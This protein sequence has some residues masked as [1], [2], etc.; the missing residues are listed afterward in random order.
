MKKLLVL[1][2]EGN[3]ETGF[4]VKWEIGPDGQRPSAKD[5]SRLAFPACPK[6]VQVYKEWE[7]TYRSL[8]GNRIKPNPNQITNVKYTDLLSTCQRNA[9]NLELVINQWFNS[10]PL[11]RIIDEDLLKNREDEYRIII[12]SDN[13]L[14]R[15]IPWLLWKGWEKFPH[16]EISLGSPYTQRRDRIYQQ[17]VRILV[18]LGNE[19]G[20]DINEDRQILENYRQQGAYV[21]FLVQP[22]IEELRRQLSDECGWDT[23]S[24]SGHSR[25]ELGNK[26]RIYINQTDSLTM[27]QLQVELAIAI[28]KGLQLAIFNSCDGLGI[29]AELEALYI[30]QVIVMRQPVP[31]RVAQKFLKYFLAEFTSGK[32]LY[33]S[34][35]IARHQLEELQSDFPC[36]SWLPVIIQNH[37]EIPPTWQ[38]LGSIP[39]CPYR[40][41]AAFRVEDK[42][43]FYGREA[44][45]QSLLNAI[46]SQSIVTLVGASGSGKSS[47]VFAGLVPNLGGNWQ[48]ISLRPESNL[49]EA[50]A[51]AISSLIPTDVNME[52][53]QLLTSALVRAIQ[54]SNLALGNFISQYQIFNS[55]RYLLL[56]I[57]QLEEL[58][59]LEIDRVQQEFFLSNIFN[60]VERFP[61]FKLLSVLRADCDRYIRSDPIWANILGLFSTQSLIPMTRSE[62]TDALII[63]AQHLNV[64]FEL[65]LVE[66][67]LD[68]FP[69]KDYSLPLLESIVTQLWEK[70]SDGYLTHSA[71]ENIGRAEGIITVRA[72]L[73]YNQSTPQDREILRT[74][75]TQLIKVGSNNLSIRRTAKRPELGNDSWKLVNDLA[76]ARLVAIDRDEITQSETVELIHDALFH[77]WHTFLK[78]IELDGDFRQW[79]EQLRSDIARWEKSNRNDDKLLPASSLDTAI[80]W[81]DKYPQTNLSE[82]EFIDLSSIKIKENNKNK[83]R[84]LIVVISTIGA[85]I[86]GSATIYQLYNTNV[87]ENT[88]RLTATAISFATQEITALE[89]A[90]K[91]VENI[92][93][94]NQKSDVKL[95]AIIT[96]LNSLTHIHERKISKLSHSGIVNSV[97]FSQDNLMIVSIN[98]NTKLNIYDVDKK[99]TQSLPFGGGSSSQLV[100][101]NDK[102]TII[103]FSGKRL[104]SWHLNLSTGK[105]SEDS[106]ITTNENIATVGFSL[107]S[108]TLAIALDRK[109]GVQLYK[110]SNNNL[111]KDRLLDIS[112]YI[113]CLKFTPDGNK[114]VT[115]NADGTVKLWAVTRQPQPLILQ[116]SEKTLTVAISPDGESIATGSDRGNIQLWNIQGKPLYSVKHNDRKVKDLN[117][118]PDSKIL[119]STKEQEIEIWKINDRKLKFLKLLPV[120]TNNTQSV[121]FNP[122]KL[123]IQTLVSGNTDGTTILWQINFPPSDFNIPDSHTFNYS[124]DGKSLAV[125]T[126]KRN[127]IVISPKQHKRIVDYPTNHKSKITGVSISSDRQYFATVAGDNDEIKLWK[128]DGENSRPLEILNLAGSPCSFSPKESIMAIATKNNIVSIYDVKGK[129]NLSWGTNQST[130]TYLSFTPDG[131]NIITGDIDGKV[132]L[133]SLNGGLF[134]EFQSSPGPVVDV[135]SNPDGIIAIAS[136]LDREGIVTLWSRDGKPIHTLNKLNG[137]TS[138]AFSQDGN[139]ILTGN[140]EGELQLW[141]LS[142]ESLMSK[143]LN[144]GDENTEISKVR[145]STNDREIVAVD[146]NGKTIYYNLDSEQL[147]QQA[148]TL[149]LKSK[150]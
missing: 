41:L 100:I 11:S 91:A 86:A 90:Q 82:R 22:G 98:D 127:I 23:I 143:P 78:W 81:S 63:P 122:I 114:I 88:R 8:D 7:N 4:D 69:S 131:N 119:A 72:E 107:N 29:A 45:I 103:S 43:Y 68:S 108:Q 112:D 137:I 50:L 132:K 118:S 116:P 133:W 148:N 110:K 129:V 40:G 12:C 2:L 66:K 6:I 16:L 74:I 150:E 24:F 61:K 30:P 104:A 42:D 39:P 56:I 52:E 126:Q 44:S 84:R 109:A 31:D 142:G 32:S 17:Q 139:V 33:E 54:T 136:G 147:Q 105:W 9:D 1:N 28:E 111:T 57:D 5:I 26:G 128:L 135:S 35:S 76:V 13:P 21:E 83:L 25:T 124:S 95:P 99:T 71:Y 144:T 59:T 46:N 20:I 92:S 64:K 89:I 94:S 67:I 77:N 140:N 27:A 146:I 121:N 80:K 49:I 87:T 73:F 62:L 117:F 18:I 141:D 96:L 113:D 70:Q 97:A 36:A 15:H 48:A 10:S 102:Q 19:E 47:M 75:F 34:V 55:D 14:V 85:M 65:N 138:L 130:L 106:L 37:L 123:N 93:R 58:Y 115:A 125:G 51:N 53:S 38:S 79:Q 120:N 149:L 101:S 134:R 60:V 3:F 145:F